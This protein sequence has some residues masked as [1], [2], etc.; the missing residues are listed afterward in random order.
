VHE[1]WKNDETLCAL[2]A[3]DGAW[4]NTIERKLVIL[5]EEVSGILPQKP[6]A[7]NFQWLD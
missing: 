3:M 5:P 6:L 1:I 2:V 7:G 4:M